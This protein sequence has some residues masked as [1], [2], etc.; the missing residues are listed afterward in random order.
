MISAVY[1]MWLTG[2]KKFQRFGYTALSFLSGVAL[3][4]VLLIVKIP[5]TYGENRYDRLTEVLKEHE[6]SYGYGEFWSANVTTILSD[7]EVKIRPIVIQKSGDYGI[8]RYQSQPDWYEDQPEVNRYFVFLSNDEYK[9]VAN[10]LV[11]DSIEE[12]PFDENGTILV[13]DYNICN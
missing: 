7:S 12:I 1:A 2:Q 9:Y 5:S 4:I 6:L 8:S 10:T 13:F 3:L 11:K